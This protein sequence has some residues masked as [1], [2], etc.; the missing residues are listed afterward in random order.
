MN[1]HKIRNFNYFHLQW[2]CMNFLLNLKILE[3]LYIIQVN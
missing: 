2:L 1:I 3:Q